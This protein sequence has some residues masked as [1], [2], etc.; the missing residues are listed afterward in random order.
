MEIGDDDVKG[1]WVEGGDGLEEGP[2]GFA[3]L[4]EYGW[5]FHHVVGVDVGEE[6]EHS[7]GA[8]GP[9]ILP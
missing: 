9:C 2:E 3:G 4:V 8:E 6:V 5:G 7:P 1:V